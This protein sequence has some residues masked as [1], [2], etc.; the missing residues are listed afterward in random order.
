M[1]DRYVG[2]LGTG[3]RGERAE[4]KGKNKRK[5]RK[6]MWTDL[7]ESGGI[8]HHEKARLCEDRWRTSHFEV[9]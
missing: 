3:G 7:G 8:H 4:V 9:T 5:Q 1:I 2:N 6:K